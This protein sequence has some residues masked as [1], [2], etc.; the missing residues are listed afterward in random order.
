ML[1]IYTVFMR[2]EGA[3]IVPQGYT[4]EAVDSAYGNP[5]GVSCLDDGNGPTPQAME[6]ARHQGQRVTGFATVL[7]NDRQATVVA[8]PAR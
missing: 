6:A 1:S 3:L 8:G 7:A 4:D 2:F 5:Y